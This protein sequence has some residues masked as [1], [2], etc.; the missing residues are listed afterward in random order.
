MTFGASHW[1]YVARWQ[2]L[3]NDDGNRKQITMLPSRYR[4]AGNEISGRIKRTAECLADVFV[5]RERLS[6][7]KIGNYTP[8]LVNKWMLRT[9]AP[10]LVVCLWDVSVPC[11]CTGSNPNSDTFPSLAPLHRDCDWPKSTIPPREMN[12]WIND[13]LCSCRALPARGPRCWA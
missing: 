12:A 1:D 3:K 9:T 5:W 8:R 10:T 7:I 4:S 13:G 6:Q 11:R 2:T